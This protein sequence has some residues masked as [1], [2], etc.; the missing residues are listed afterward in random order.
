MPQQPPLFAGDELPFEANSAL[1]MRVHS[2][3]R[4]LS[5]EQQR[6]NR[7][8]AELEK[9]QTQTQA[10]EQLT[11]RFRPQFSAGLQPL[12][13]QFLLLERQMIEFLH[14]RLQR[15]GL[16]KTQLS[17]ARQTLCG[18]CEPHAQAGDT[19]LKAI[20][21]QHSDQSLDEEEQEDLQLTREILQNEM[22]VDLSGINAQS[23]DDL[24]AQAMQRLHARDQAK[25]QAQEEK[26]A[27]KQSAKKAAAQAA[28]PPQAQ[29]AAEHTDPKSL[30]RSLYRQL[31]SDLHPDREPDEALRAEKT[32]LM[33]QANT[34]YQNA[35]LATLLHL[36]WR[37]QQISP[38]AMAQ[39]SQARLNALSSLLKAQIKTAKDQYAAAQHRLHGELQVPFGVP[40]TDSGLL[41]YLASEK[42][43][44]KNT[45]YLME[46]DLSG[47]QDDKSLKIWL[48]EQR[49]IMKENERFYN[50]LDDMGL[51]Y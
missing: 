11:D 5:P 8:L 48:K 23:A 25:A 19:A 45:L 41:N 38:E 39:W 2:T 26:R 13:E 3:G 37:T 27:A 31:A 34:A 43:K 42:L 14:Q 6:F 12:R 29:S 33:S 47:I 35:D 15:P 18:L 1:P 4:K 46:T 50:Q 21:D 36:Q 16:T 32:Q 17:T 51:Y 22:G 20:Y 49:Q 40:L 7:Q 30:L 44:W 10:V 24:L 28:L 9:L